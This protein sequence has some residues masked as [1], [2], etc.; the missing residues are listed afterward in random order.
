MY[1]QLIVC[2]PVIHVLIRGIGHAIENRV[3]TFYKPSII[4]IALLR[5]DGI[6]RDVF[7]GQLIIDVPVDGDAWHEYFFTKAIPL[8]VV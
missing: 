7:K 5:F 8:V 1:R 3:T 2:G 6:A 4:H